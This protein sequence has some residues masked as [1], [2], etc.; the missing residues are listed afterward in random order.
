MSKSIN[1]GLYL[2][3][4]TA[5]AIAGCVGLMQV[6]QPWRGALVLWLGGAGTVGALVYLALRQHYAF[7]AL[8]LERGARPGV[9]RLR[10]KRPPTPQT[11]GL[12][13]ISSETATG[14]RRI[15]R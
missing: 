15:V 6:A 10:P 3:A 13:I 14:E 1:S 9:A 7:R 11:G 8:E 2:L 12:R 4:V 5:V